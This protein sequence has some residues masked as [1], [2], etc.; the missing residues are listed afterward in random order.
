MRVLVIG[1]GGREHALVW[2]L[3][4]SKGLTKLYC[5]PGNP[6]IG[7]LAE[8]V[9]IQSTDITSLCEFAKAERIDLTVVG[10]EQPLASGIV[11]LFQA[12]SLQIFGPTKRA[13][14]LE[15]SKSFAKDFMLRHRIP[16]ARHRTFSRLEISDATAHVESINLPVVIKANGLAAGKGVA[17]CTSLEEA[18]LA[19]DTMMKM[20]NGESV[21]IEEFL[22]GEEASVFAVCDGRSYVVLAPAQD[23]KR[24]FD[25]DRGKNTGGMGAYAPA[26]VVSG[27]VLEIVQKQIIGPTLRGMMEEGRPYKGCLYCGLMITTDG[28]KVIEYNCRFGDPETQVVIP[29]YE[30]DLLK[31][32]LAACG[33]TVSDFPSQTEHGSS[34]V[35]VVLAS[36]GYPDSYQTEFPISGLDAVRKIPDVLVFHAGTKRQGDGIVTAGGRVLAVTAWTKNESLRQA[37]DNAYD[38]VQLVSFREM[39]FR[40]DIGR[41]AFAHEEPGRHVSAIAKSE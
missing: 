41:K 5:A 8:C 10:P 3:S 9:P 22:E 28:P 17:I 6:G 31:L 25:G 16:T 21:V 18:H 26:S 4:Q 1:S 32:L 34:A 37:I 27:E 15:W 11:D 30:G 36:G 40:K 13:A 14:E 24:V 7:E 33:D 23:H 35:C 39:H 29:L 20:G 19:L 2:K 12:E 38:A